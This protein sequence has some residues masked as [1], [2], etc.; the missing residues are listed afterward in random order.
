MESEEMPPLAQVLPYKRYTRGQYVIT[1]SKRKKFFKLGN[2]K[3]GVPQG[4][5]LG[6]VLLF[7]YINDLPH[8]IHHETKPVIYAENKNTVNC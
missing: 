6:P 5:I 7:I 8:G 4:S 2:C 1:N 3:Y